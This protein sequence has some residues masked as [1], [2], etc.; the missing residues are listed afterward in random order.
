MW[1]DALRAAG[2]IGSALP[3]PTTPL[4]A[5]SHYD[6]CC[7]LSFR[8][9]SEDGVNGML[10]GVIRKNVSVLGL[11]PTMTTTAHVQIRPP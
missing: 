7:P 9:L 1:D 4:S 5:L 2:R 3:T 10:R 11:A 6:C 8:N